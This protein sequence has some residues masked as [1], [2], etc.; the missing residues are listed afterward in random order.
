[1]GGEREESEKIGRVRRRSE[2]AGKVPRK[3]SPPQAKHH[4]AGSRSTAWRWPRREVDERLPDAR[5]WDWT[6]LDWIGLD[7]IGLDWKCCRL[8]W[9]G[10]M[11]LQF[12]VWKFWESTLAGGECR[13]LAAAMQQ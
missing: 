10:G 13:A 6:G 7:W 4:H 1:M 9:A 5:S 8:C 3:V 11:L 12:W 2:R